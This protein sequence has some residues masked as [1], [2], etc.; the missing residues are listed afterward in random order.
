MNGDGPGDSATRP[1]VARVA[2]VFYGVMAGV[3]SV[4]AALRG[5]PGV[6]A[7]AAGGAAPPVQAL[8][9]AAFGLALV[10]ASRWASAR[11]VWAQRLD[12][13]LKALLGPL[14]SGDMALLAGT[15]ALAEEMLFRG[16]MLPDLGLV[17]SSL[18]FGA[19]HLPPRR[20]LWQWSVS[21]AV[22]GLGLGLLYQGTGSI[23][24]PV[25]AHFT[26]NWFNLRTLGAP[27][28]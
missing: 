17:A 19:A 14:S 10:G 4:W 15:S 28:P 8:W 20:D 25:V 5:E 18:A 26:V 7:Q 12:A 27:G 2:L 24:G 3:A 6:F 11:L 1:R 21:T 16:A 23:L 22:V 13:E 9:G